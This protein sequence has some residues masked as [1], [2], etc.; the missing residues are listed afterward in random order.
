MRAD[1][2]LEMSVCVCG[3]VC[4]CVGVSVCM[5]VCER[6]YVCVCGG[7]GVFLSGANSYCDL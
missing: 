4:T 2:V 3:Q 1:T 5:C 7:G 6:V